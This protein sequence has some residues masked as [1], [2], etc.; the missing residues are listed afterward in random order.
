MALSS[1][2]TAG[3]ATSPVLSEAPSNIQIT[4]P[5]IIAL[6]EGQWDSFNRQKINQLLQQ[7]GKNSDSYDAKKPPY[8]VFDW[9]NTS[10][11]LDIQEA[12]MI[13]Q[14][15][16]LQ[17]AM[18]PEEMNLAI[19]KDIPQTDFSPEYN[20]QEG[21][22]VNIDKIAEDIVSSY[23]WIYENYDQMAG[24]QPLTAI[25]QSPQFQDFIAK[26]RYLY[27]AIGDTFDHSVSYPWATY[28]F[29]GLTEDALRKMTAETVKWQQTQPIESVTW[30]SPDS[31]SGKA[32][33]IKISWKNGLR[34]VPEMQDLYT[35]LRQAGFDVYVCSASFVD[36]VKEISSNP[37]F[38]Y[39]NN[40]QHVI[41]MELERDNQGVIQSEFRKGYVQTQGKGKTEAIHQFL[42][43]KYGYGPIMIAGDSEGDQNMMQDF[44][45]TKLVLIINR[46]RSNDSDIGQLSQKA[47]KEYKAPEAKYLLQGRDEN[48]GVFIPSQLHIKLGETEGKVVR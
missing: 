21:Q 39:L 43:K 19:R 7:Y 41:A 42:V 44:E 2:V 38:N 35:K 18:T 17:Y 31:L 48:L 10:I 32:G 15:E 14:L 40:D 23:R 8:V 24:Q 36:V 16:N 37:D 5:A 4:T 9:D 25:K 12:L 26:M 6:E 27:E 30:T 22:P 13:Y 28:H 3:M 34:L 11:F 47:A 45:D 1:I 46:L 33:V 20:N 29:T